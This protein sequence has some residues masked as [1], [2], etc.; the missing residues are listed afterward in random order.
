MEEQPLNLV[1]NL[2]EEQMKLLEDKL[3]K[4]ETNID[5]QKINQQQ[6]NSILDLSNRSQI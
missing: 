5:I 4:M 3:E 6:S 1:N 2:D